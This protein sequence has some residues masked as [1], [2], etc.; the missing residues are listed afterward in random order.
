MAGKKHSVCIC[1]IIVSYSKCYQVILP[2][3]FRSPSELRQYTLLEN[4]K[5]MAGYQFKAGNCCL[6]CSVHHRV[7]LSE[8]I[9]GYQGLEKI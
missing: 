4:N 7:I 9:D 3:Y 2:T 8:S 1:R 5:L 6:I